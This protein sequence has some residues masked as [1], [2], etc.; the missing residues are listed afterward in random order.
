MQGHVI[1]AGVF[2]SEKTLGG[3]L[4]I[5]CN[6]IACITKNPESLKIRGFP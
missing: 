3:P 5:H 4:V 6:T 1:V 2:I